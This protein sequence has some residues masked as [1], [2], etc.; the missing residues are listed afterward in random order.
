M[1][2]A[3]GMADITTTA[4]N[5]TKTATTGIDSHRNPSRDSAAFCKRA[6]KIFERP[7]TPDRAATVRTLC[8]LTRLTSFN[9]D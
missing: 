7:R 1:P 4:A 8:T 5:T 2:T 3:T 6:H 9:A